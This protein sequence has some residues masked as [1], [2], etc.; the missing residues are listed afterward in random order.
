M[1]E[2]VLKQIP[3]RIIQISLKFIKYLY[4]IFIY[5]FNLTL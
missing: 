1:E 2:T 3:I 4:Y 5:L